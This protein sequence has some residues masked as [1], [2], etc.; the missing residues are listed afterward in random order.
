[1]IDFLKLARDKHIHTITSG[2]RHARAGWVNM[3]CPM[4]SGRDYHLGYNLRT[5]AFACWRCGALRFWTV[6]PALLGLP[7]EATKRTLRPYWGSKGVRVAPSV[8]EPLKIRRRE[9]KPPPGT[10]PCLLIPHENYL[11]GRG[12]DPT[13]LSEEWGIKGT[14]HLGG[15]WGWRIIIPIYNGVDTIVAY[16][17]RTIGKA[18]PKYLMT[19]NDKCLEDPNTFLYGIHR[20]EGDSVVVV[21]GATGVW[22]IGPGTLGVL[23]IG[24]KKEQANRLRRFSQRF[25]LFD[26]EPKA[27]QRAR[28]LAEEL[29]LFP[30]TTEILSGF[31]TD[32]GELTVRQV[33]RVRRAAGL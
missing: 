1:M 14:N 30:G 28:L 33:E 26:P 2:H 22:R 27:Q 10:L 29:S 32:P 24:W 17:G 31:S 3:H 13:H 8:P 23:G 12:F 20:A 5:G 21:E 18:E 11:R 16:Q 25:I 6:M 9:I 7:L 4:C 15:K 19:A